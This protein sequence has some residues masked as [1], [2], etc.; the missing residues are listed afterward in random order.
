MALITPNFKEI[1]DQY[2]EWANTYEQDAKDWSYSSPKK[3]A[4]RL[5]RYLKPE[6]KMVDL[7]CGTGLNGPEYNDLELTLVG[8]DSSQKML[9][10]AKQ[11]GYQIVQGDIGKTPFKDNQ[12][13]ASICI[14]VLENFPDICPYVQEMARIVKPSGIITFT[15]ACSQIEGL[16]R[17]SKKQLKE[18]LS[19]CNLKELELFK[20]LSHKEDRIKPIYFW[21]A[22]NLNSK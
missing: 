6:M 22:I 1:Q 2:N 17:N 14:T 19:K 3:I 7:G 21:A 13:D 20:F 4:E 15:V 12:F 8:I 9:K 18:I 11:K 10:K 16:Y 5:K